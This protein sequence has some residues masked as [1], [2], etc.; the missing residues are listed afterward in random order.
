MYAKWMNEPRNQQNWGRWRG[1]GQED[2]IKAGNKSNAE[3][4]VAM[5]RLEL[6]NEQKIM[7]LMEKSLVLDNLWWKKFKLNMHEATGI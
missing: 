7:Q 6:D 2:V 1:R 4:G 5:R 3:E